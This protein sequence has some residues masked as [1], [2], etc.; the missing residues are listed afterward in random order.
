MKFD[1]NTGVAQINIGEL[2][3][4]LAENELANVYEEQDGIQSLVGC[5]ERYEF[6][7]DSDS[8]DLNESEILQLH[9]ITHELNETIKKLHELDRR[10]HDIA[11]CR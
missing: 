3:S 1:D 9:Q 10:F 7:P 4:I 11:D 6:V 5:V 8:D 2:H